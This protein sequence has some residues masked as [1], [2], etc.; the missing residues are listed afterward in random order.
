MDT[1]VCPE[2]GRV[3]PA[4]TMNCEQ[5]RINLQFAF[6]HPDQIEKTSVV[7]QPGRHYIMT[8]RPM[9]APS[10]IVE[11]PPQRYRSEALGYTPQRYQSD[12]LGN[13]LYITIPSPKRWTVTIIFTLWV[14]LCTLL[15]GIGVWQLFSGNQTDIS[16]YTWIIMFV[17]FDILSIYQLLW[18][19]LG[20]EVIEITPDSI[21]IRHAILG[22][23][24]SSV[25]ASKNVS[26]MR[27]D[28]AGKVDP[29]PVNSGG[30]LLTKG[31][32]M[33]AFDYQ[34]QTIRMGIGLVE[35]EAER[36]VGEIQWQYPQY[37]RRTALRRR[38]RR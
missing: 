19:I 37:K 12:A 36:L 23:G 20:K 27:V 7:Q 5:C 30:M 21:A 35:A 15:G 29:Y 34:R 38:R 17:V 13:T 33:I 28:R 8:Y 26:N 2:C 6:E 3:N 11:A 25:Y 14:I 4:N 10:K 32:G 16:V 18:Q 22:I 24:R 1:I 31:T 9:H